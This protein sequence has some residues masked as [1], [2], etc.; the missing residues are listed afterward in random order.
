MY[1]TIY[2]GLGSNLGQKKRNLNDALDALAKVF[3]KPLAV[4]SIYKSEAWGFNSV[5]SFLNLV[6]SFRINL[7]PQETLRICLTIEKELGRKEKTKSSY[8]SRKIDIDIL[9]FGE[10]TIN[11][12]D[13][14]IPHPFI[15]E[16]LFVLQPLFEICKETEII[17]QYD[18]FFKKIK[19]EQLLEKIT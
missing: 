15:K 12:I 14:K 4:S 10:I 6:V 17:N 5:N 13:L 2:L 16:R 11:K 19:I 3:G 9:I 7:N 1:R 18:S 8:E